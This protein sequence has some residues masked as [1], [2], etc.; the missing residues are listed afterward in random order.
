MLFCLHLFYLPAFVSAFKYYSNDFGGRGLRASVRT[1]ALELLTRPAH[2][3]S[4]NTHTH[5]CSF[6]GWVLV[7]GAGTRCSTAHHHPF[8][9]VIVKHSEGWSALQA[10]RPDDKMLK[11]SKRGGKKKQP[12]TT[13]AGKLTST[14]LA[15][16]NATC[17]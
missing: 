10:L 6:Q 7:P 8:S 11:M 9:P 5:T 14:S 16:G 3:L 13:P 4:V 2:V 1:T 12:K 17:K 15:P